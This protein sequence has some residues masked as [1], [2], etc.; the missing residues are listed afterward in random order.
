MKI[1][2]ILKD[3]DKKKK[4]DLESI[5]SS[6]IS[7]EVPPVIEKPKRRFFWDTDQ[8][9]KVQSNDYELDNQMSPPS[10]KNVSTTKTA[11]KS[12]I[13]IQTSS[14]I[15][16]VIS[17]SQRSHIGVETESNESRNGVTTE[18]NKT[19]VAIKKDRK[20]QNGVETE[21]QRSHSKTL[22]GVETES[23]NSTNGVLTESKR[24]HNCIDLFNQTRGSENSF[25]WFIFNECQLE[26]ALNTSFISLNHIKNSLSL[27]STDSTKSLVKRVVNKGLVKRVNRKNGRAGNC[28]YG[29]DETFYRYLMLKSKKR[30]LNGV[31][32][33]SNQSSNGV[34]TESRLCN[35]GVEVGV[36][37]DSSMYVGNLNNNTIHTEQPKQTVPATDEIWTDLYEIDFNLLAQW[38]IR[39]NV[40][41][42][43]K[44]NKWE[45]SRIQLEEFIER[46]FR[47]FSEKEF[48][49]RR[50]PIKSPYSFFLSSI[51]AIS[52]GEPD[53]ICD[54]KT[55]F[56]IAQE[57]AMQNKMKELERRRREYEVIEKQLEQYLESEYSY[58]SSKLSSEEKTSIAPTNNIAKLGSIAHNLILKNHFVQNIWPEIKNNFVKSS[59]DE[60]YSEGTELSQ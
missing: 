43:L 5:P 17:E 58:W 46:F 55:Q 25:I 14:A 45:V 29:L 24:S 10:E 48:E 41:E 12:N 56:Q 16:G 3:Q 20:T 44:K 47:Y 32:S 13:L 57:L 28:Q 26:A 22:I 51:K 50:E 4:K 2:D 36:E 42:T 18:S 11:S 33:E 7:V 52:K 9:E 31:V 39:T 40:I 27:I 49:K 54:I 37:L 23:L 38:N 34:L 35:N 1:D 21:S 30:S 53:P 8:S 6:R 15:N 59:T 19:I 60:N